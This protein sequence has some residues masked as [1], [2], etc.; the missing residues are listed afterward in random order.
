MAIV[1]GGGDVVGGAVG[2]DAGVCGAAWIVGEGAGV[3]DGKEG[4]MAGTTLTV[5]RVPVDCL[6]AHP[7]NYRGHPESQRAHIRASLVEH[8]QYRNVVV[9]QDDTVL[10]GHGVWLSAKDLGWTHI[11][12]I[13]LPIASDSP[14]AYKVLV[15]DNEISTGADI[16]DRTL[17][18]LLRAVRD[19][20]GIDALLGTGYSQEQLAA[21][22]FVTRPPDQIATA[23]EADEW[24]G[25]PEY[26]QYLENIR[27]SV[28]FRTVEDRARF[29]ELIGAKATEKT[30]TIWWPH[31]D[32]DTEPVAP[33]RSPGNMIEASPD[34]FAAATGDTETSA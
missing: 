6:R 24:V 23:D 21:L 1:G 34:A 27:L 31:R 19:E 9:A 22:V 33:H 13:R 16:D 17:V 28:Q 32:R 12:V 2:A 10:A 5:E 15:G 29:L 25:M 20:S 7:R 11:D 4:R 3:V 14:A 30:K 18:D 26:Q 8:G